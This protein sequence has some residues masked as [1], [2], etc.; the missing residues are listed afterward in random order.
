MC[1]IYNSGGITFRPPSYLLTHA[2][3]EQND[4]LRRVNGVIR[5]INIKVKFVMT[6]MEYRFSLFMTPYRQIRCEKQIQIW[7]DHTILCNGGVLV[8][9]N[10]NYAVSNWN[11][12]GIS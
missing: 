5:A 6:T 4:N 1:V 7:A 11:Y 3:T 12:N 10:W 8:L 9:L 2:N